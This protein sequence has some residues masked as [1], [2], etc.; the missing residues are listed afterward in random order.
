MSQKIDMELSSFSF[1]I[2]EQV[3]Q[4]NKEEQTEKMTRCIAQTKQH[5]QCKN[6]AKEGSSFCGV[7]QSA[8]YCTGVT[9]KG[10]PCKAQRFHET[11][12]CKH[13]QNQTKTVS[14]DCEL[15]RVPDLLEKR[16]DVVME[17]RNSIDAYTCKAICDTPELNLD[18]VVELY[19]LR[20]CFDLV[21]GNDDDKQILLSLV[22]FNANRKYN[23]NFTTQTIN[24]AKHCAVKS[25]CEDF[26][27]NHCH[28]DGLR[29][30]LSK[31]S[32]DEDVRSRIVE[33]TYI[34]MDHITLLFCEQDEMLGNV[35]DFMEKMVL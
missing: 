13:H 16:R 5:K 19:L 21:P 26:R 8:N 10:E 6:N 35:C 18:H 32:L 27:D 23:L 30:Y 9:L 34:S 33:Q 7:H 24:Q 28:M 2:A 15:F 3:K 4:R 14:T 20:D 25:F 22:R 12:F 17:Y 29:H 11:L 31:K 1:P